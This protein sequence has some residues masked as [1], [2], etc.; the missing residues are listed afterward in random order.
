MEVGIF[1]MSDRLIRNFFKQQSYTINYSSTIKMLTHKRQFTFF[2]STKKMIKLYIARTTTKCQE[3]E[4]DI[5]VI[6]N[7]T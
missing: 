1:E 7:C 2:S 3:H 4:L 6:K 5:E